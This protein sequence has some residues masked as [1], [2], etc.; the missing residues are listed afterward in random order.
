MEEEKK[1]KKGKGI[2]IIIFLLLLAIAACCGLGYYIYYISNNHQL[3][4]A[5]A[6]NMISSLQSDKNSLTEQVKKLEE[7]PETE[8]D[9]KEENTET[10]QLYV[11]TPEYTYILKFVAGLTSDIY[12]P[13]LIPDFDDVRKLDSKYLSLMAWSHMNSGYLNGNIYELQIKRSYLN[14]VLVKVFG[15]RANGIIDNSSFKVE[16]PFELNE[17][18]ETYHWSGFDG[19]EGSGKGFIIDSIIQNGSKYSVKLLEYKYEFD[20]EEDSKEY[21]V[22]YSD[23]K[24]NVILTVHEKN[25]YDDNNEY[26]ETKYYDKNNNEIKFEEEI[27]YDEN[28]NYLYTNR[29]Y[30]KDKLKDKLTVQELEL[31]FDKDH[32]ILLSAKT[33]K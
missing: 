4:M 20:W 19:P 5:S 12:G 8:T 30:L 17:D 14:T 21:D 6:N 22:K 29:S 9:K 26:V 32:F 28:E 15:D 16:F 1:K 24:N 3:E 2:G 33:V 10:K 11:N 7:K 27:V 18:G 13:E 25:I 31:E 23:L